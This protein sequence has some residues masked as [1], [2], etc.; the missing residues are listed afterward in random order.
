MKVKISC[1]SVKESD[2]KSGFDLICETD[3]GQQ[4]TMCCHDKSSILDA[5]SMFGLIDE[6]KHQVKRIIV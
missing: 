1:I 5:A 6:I 3:R 2:Y 4:I